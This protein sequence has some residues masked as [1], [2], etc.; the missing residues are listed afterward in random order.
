[1]TIYEDSAP[2]S[3]SLFT[4]PAQTT[5]A[6]V[7]RRS[8]EWF[9]GNAA[10]VLMPK[11]MDRLGRCLPSCPCPNSNSLGFGDRDGREATGP[12]TPKTALYEIGISYLY[13]FRSIRPLKNRGGGEARER[14]R[15]RATPPS[16][17]C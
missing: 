17:S 5:V 7:L 12:A 9:D 2:V 13:K 8:A 3:P 14:D 6:A 1:M 10:V 4:L 11:A 15:L 16:A